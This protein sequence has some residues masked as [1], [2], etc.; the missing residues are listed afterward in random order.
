MEK[1][2]LKKAASRGA[3]IKLLFFRK[4]LRFIYLLFFSRAYFG[5]G[6]IIAMV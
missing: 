2:A 5:V 6:I 3:K 4:V 1:K